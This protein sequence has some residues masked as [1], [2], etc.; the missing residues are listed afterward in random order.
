MTAAAAM[1][2]S[3]QPGNIA[4]N[5]PSSADKRGSWRLMASKYDKQL[6]SP[7]TN[8]RRDLPNSGGVWTIG[9]N[10]WWISVN[11]QHGQRQHRANMLAFGARIGGRRINW[12]R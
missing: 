4:V 9:E 7:T 3:P 8:H 11:I 2:R 6:A 12:F 10:V 1:V 5:L